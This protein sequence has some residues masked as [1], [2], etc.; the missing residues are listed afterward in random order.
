MNR[1]MSYLEAGYGLGPNLEPE[2]PYLTADQFA[3]KAPSMSAQLA[4]VVRS[5]FRGIAGR[6][7]YIVIAVGAERGFGSPL[8]CLLVLVGIFRAGWAER[9]WLAEGLILSSAGLTL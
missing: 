7:A 3:L 1:G 8:I 4:T 5:Y 9:R 6:T 2:G